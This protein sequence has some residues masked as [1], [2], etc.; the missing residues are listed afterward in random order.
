MVLTTPS[1]VIPISDE[2]ECYNKTTESWY[3]PGENGDHLSALNL[4]LAFS[5]N[6]TV[7]Y[8]RSPDEGGKV[9]IVVVE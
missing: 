9:R 7:Y 1:M 3:K 6:I 8:D 5:D 2:V 4:A